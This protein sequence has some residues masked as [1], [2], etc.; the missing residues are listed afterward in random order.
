M[1]YC[2]SL[3]ILTESSTLFLDTRR[4]CRCFKQ[5]HGDAFSLYA[6]HINEFAYSYCIRTLPT[7]PCYLPTPIYS[8]MQFKYLLILSVVLG[9]AAACKPVL[10]SCAVNSECCGD[11]CV[12][13]LCI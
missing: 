7:N 11:L 9:F 13:G 5:T 1:N 6:T 3:H 12:A 8:T 2:M 4:M 10:Q